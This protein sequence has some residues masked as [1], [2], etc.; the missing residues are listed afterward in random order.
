LKPSVDIPGYAIDFW[1]SILSSA[2]CITV[3]FLTQS[4]YYTSME[5]NLI[6]G[7]EK[8]IFLQMSTGPC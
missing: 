2:D 8:K 7:R 6:L 4:I 1:C 3:E 5:L